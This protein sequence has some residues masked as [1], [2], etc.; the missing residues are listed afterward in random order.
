MKI[1][2]VRQMFNTLCIEHN[3]ELNVPIEVNGRLTSTLGRVRYLFV[4]NI[5]VPINVEFSKKHL[6]LSSKEEIIDT[7]KHEFVHYYLIKTDPTV[8]HGHDKVFKA[9][10]TKIGCIPKATKSGTY[11]DEQHKYSIYCKGCG[12]LIAHRDRA[13]KLTKNPN[14]YITKCCGTGLEVHQNY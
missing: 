11:E 6:E 12:K 14:L 2:E 9:F 8:R 5:Y 4:N 3:V 10:C 7:I 13:C 1:E